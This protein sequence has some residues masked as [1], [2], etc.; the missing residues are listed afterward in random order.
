MTGG[1]RLRNSC[2][3]VRR[4]KNGRWQARPYCS[5]EKE[6]YNLGIFNTREAAEAAVRAFWKTSR[7]DRRKFVKPV[8]YRDGSTRYAATLIITLGRHD[9]PEQAADV[10]R[11]FLARR[12]PK[13]EAA[14]LVGRREVNPKAP[15]PNR[16]ELYAHLAARRKLVAELHA[17]G[18]TAAA[19]GTALGATESQVGGDLRRIAHRAPQESAAARELPKQHPHPPEP[20]P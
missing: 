11:D 13:E 10:V 9:S 1:A 6:R 12:L 3:Y 19:I 2:T 8:H 5:I 15:D 14:R 18:W 17:A 4:V 7:G 16:V 20:G